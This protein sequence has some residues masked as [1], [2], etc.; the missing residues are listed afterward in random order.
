[1]ET[2]K[3]KRIKL[4]KLIQ[5]GGGFKC[6]DDAG[7]FAD[8]PCDGCRYEAS[9]DCVAE[10]IADALIQN[11]V[12]ILECGMDCKNCWKTK[13]VNPV[14][15]WVSVDEP[16]TKEGWYHVAILDM[17]TGKYRVENDLYSIEIAKAHNH[18]PGFCK[19]KSWPERDKL[20]HW[21]PYPEPPKGVQ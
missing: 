8:I 20:T 3:E 16:P 6:G 21:C 19:A 7:T 2:V 12:T 1:M 4:I 15:E 18:E 17:K 11:G 14:H 9:E 5:N 10:R 13:L